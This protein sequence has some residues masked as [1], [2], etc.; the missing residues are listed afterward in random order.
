MV[1]AS[2]LVLKTT[3]RH[4][5]CAFVCGRNIQAFHGLRNVQEK[6]DRR[7]YY[8]YNENSSETDTPA[9][10]LQGLGLDAK[11][12]RKVFAVFNWYYNHLRGLTD[13]NKVFLLTSNGQTKAAYT[14]LFAEKGLAPDALIDMNDFVVQHQ[15]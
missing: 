1:A 3:G 10:Q 12:T 6:E 11:L 5:T 13:R 15:A 4:L 14:S 8:F 2:T 7:F 9:A